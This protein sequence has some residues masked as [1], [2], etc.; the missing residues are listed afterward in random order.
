[1]SPS[2][3]KDKPIQRITLKVRVEAE[4]PELDSLQKRLPGSRVSKGALLQSIDASE[5][6][7][8]T[9]ALRGIADAIRATEKNPKG[10][11]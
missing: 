11:K 8:A 10:F 3:E 9:D 5:P 1:M 6:A 7:S 2:R 4:G